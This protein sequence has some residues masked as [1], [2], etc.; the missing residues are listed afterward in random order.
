MGL[1]P[2]GLFHGTVAM[3]TTQDIY[4]DVTSQTLYHDAAEG[5]PSSVT[6]VT[7]FP[8]DSS[9]NAD[10]EWSATGAVETNPNTTLDAAAGQSQ[11]NPRAVPLTATTGIAEG[12]EYLITHATS[13]LKEWAI[14]ESVTSADSVTVK[15]PLHNDYASGATFQ[16]TRITAPV[17]DSWIAD[18]A[19]IRN[20]A[21]PN[22]AYRIRWEYVVGGQTHVA[23]SYFNVVRYAGTHGVRPADV[24]STSPG[25]LDR[26]PSDHRVDQGRR[27]IDEAYRAVKIDLAAIWQ[28][29]AMVANAEIVDE[30]TRYKCLEIGALAVAMDGGDAGRLTVARDAYQRRFDSLSRITNKLPIRDETGAAAPQVAVGLTCR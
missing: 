12:R 4:F 14:V 23:D 30:L 3:R 15:H 24:E 26:L 9:D 2:L 6:S 22:P 20:D 10:S 16:S 17:D 13:G 29:D 27:L 7:V 5:R 21:G 18:E 28:D 25:W 11:P 1:R 8:W 19:N